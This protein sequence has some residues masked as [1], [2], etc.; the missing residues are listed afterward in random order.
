MQKFSAKMVERDVSQTQPLPILMPKSQ[1]R[2]PRLILA[3][4]CLISGIVS[5]PFP[6]SLPPAFSPR[7]AIGAEVPPPAQSPK[8]D[9][10]EVVKQGSEILAQGTYAERQRATLDLWRRRERT[11]D[12]VQE[13]T[14]DSD[15]EVAQ[16]AKWILRQ[17]QR[18]ALPGNTPDISRLLRQSD[19]NAAVE[20][21]LEAG[22][23]SAAVVAVEEVAGTLQRENVHSNASEALHRRF[24]IYVQM[25]IEQEA[26]PEL[27]R[28]VDLV[29]DSKEMAVCRIQLMQII[30]KPFDDTS[31][32]PS[33][34]SGWSLAER[35][36]ATVLVL[37]VLGRLDDA[38][39]QAEASGSDEL[40]RVCRMLTGSWDEIVTTSVQQARAAEDG[41]L[42][43]TRHWCRAMIAADRAGNVNIF[44]EAVAALSSD[45][46]ER[47]SV[48]TNLSWQCL[49]S[50][51]Q[52][53]PALKLLNTINPNAAAQVA[54]AASRTHE[55]FEILGYPVDEVDE[56]LS[57]WIREAIE[58]Q[59]VLQKEPRG[60]GRLSVET[61][62]LLML[63]R[64]LLMVGRDDAAWR[65]ADTLSRSDVRVGSSSIRDSVLASLTMVPSRSDWIVDLAVLPGERM[66]SS[67]AE[68]A[69]VETLGDTSMGTWKILMDVIATLI[70]ERSFDQRLRI[71]YE[72]FQGNIPDGFD[73]DRDFKRVYDR[74]TTG[75][76]RSVRGRLVVPNRSQIN[77][78]FADLFT[79]HGQ[80]E[81]ATQCLR[82]LLQ[83]G[84]MAAALDIAQRELDGG[85]LQTA[86]TYLNFIWDQTAT[87]SRVRREFRLGFKD[88]Q[89]ATKALVGQ[90]TV[91]R[92]EGDRL[93][94]DA[95]TQQMRL[96]LCTPS[97]ELRRTLAGHLIDQDE[98]ELSMEAYRALLL[99]TAM[100]S[101]E[102][103]E[104][105]FVASDYATAVR[106]DDPVS[107]AHWF[108]LAISGTLESTTFQ[109]IFYVTLP[110]SA[111][112][113]FIEAAIQ[114]GDAQ[115]ARHHVG[116]L[117]Q[118]DPMDIDFAERLLP[119]MRSS[120]MQELAD[121]TFD[122][123]FETGQQFMRD[124]PFHATTSNNL[125][126]VAA[127][128]Q[129]RLDE[130]LPLVR[131]AV[132][133]E[134]DSAIY[135]DTLAEVL[136]QRGRIKEALQ[137]EQACILDDP[138]QWHLHQQVQKYQAALADE[139][140]S[141]SPAAVPAAI[142]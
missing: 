95:L 127:M 4:I 56:H 29:A 48:S 49:A 10:E 85:D 26:L 52:I 62:S 69:I 42:E 55:A 16:R 86:K 63:M 30:G 37:A 66:I 20:E 17:W 22:Q 43:K 141:A 8:P 109:P 53:Q 104:F 24:P 118:L 13:A 76:Q 32:L 3:L 116:R 102:G 46:A 93:R 35:R 18:G 47:D 88:V 51:G 83:Q 139:A 21:L 58:S 74:L 38:L 100:G 11:R 94:T 134:P 84:E 125:A 99:M 2:F 6:A 132:E 14:R 68:A 41:S 23:F 9:G 71:V 78:E 107:A 135:R 54:M 97:T 140:E 137:I 15:P 82:Q 19:E 96:T 103:T 80:V 25:A 142:D 124:F 101:E 121:A 89:W 7:P 114:S 40:V 64:C 87:Q 126:W 60:G 120:G 77:Q 136:F 79:Q 129:R 57:R 65:I 117:T 130:A 75:N 112:R 28:L 67:K 44:D 31:L 113:M 119:K 92:R 81:L 39:R 133:R 98:K 115:A 27:V 90:W 59:R 123:L 108:D 33:A 73:P 70:P 61:S 122:A 91:A 12:Q 106:S 111:R 34:S 131:R 110:L 50:H 45:Q 5:L 138:G 72:L 128:N 105:V 1:P 36:E